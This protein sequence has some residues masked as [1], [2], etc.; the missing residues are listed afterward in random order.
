MFKKKK[1][2]KLAGL[3]LVG[4]VV[5]HVGI[6]GSKAAEGLSAF[7]RRSCFR[8]MET[9]VTYSILSYLTFIATAE[10]IVRPGKYQ[11]DSSELTYTLL[12]SEIYINDE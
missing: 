11:Q 9:L 4:E 3:W 5:H 10:K 7:Q 1:I 8:I 2:Q 6:Y 12:K